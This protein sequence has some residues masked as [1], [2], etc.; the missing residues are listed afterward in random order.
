MP[1]SALKALDSE[2]LSE[3]QL[4]LNDELKEIQR[5]IKWLEAITKIETMREREGS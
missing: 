4:K 3:L 1:I 2:D 5:T